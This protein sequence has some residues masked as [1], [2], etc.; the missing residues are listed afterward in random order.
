MLQP[1]ADAGVHT[2]ISHQGVGQQSESLQTRGGWKTPEVTGLSLGLG[3]IVETPPLTPSHSS[4][5]SRSYTVKSVLAQ[6]PWVQLG[7][8]FSV[9]KVPPQSV[10][11]QSSPPLTTV[12][13]LGAPESRLARSRVKQT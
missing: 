3:T 5:S 1:S 11:Q 6:L 9:P 12:M 2:R 4:Q 8:Q 7:P 10:S 13:S